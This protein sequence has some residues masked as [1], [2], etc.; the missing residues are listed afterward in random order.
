MENSYSDEAGTNKPYCMVRPQTLLRG[1]RVP[2]MDGGVAIGTTTLAEESG[3][4][5]VAQ[6]LS[7]GFGDEI[8]LERSLRLVGS[9]E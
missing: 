3:M 1:S 8:V 4:M 9:L 6:G 7:S 5:A 2:V